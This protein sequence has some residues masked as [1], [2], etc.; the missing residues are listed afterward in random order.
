M[1]FNCQV[2]A[3]LSAIRQCIP[4]VAKTTS[5]PVLSCV[6]IEATGG[7]YDAGDGDVTVSATNH[8]VWVYASVPGA[9]VARNGAV[10][11]PPDKLAA[12]L[13]ESSSDTV[14]IAAGGTGHDTTATVTIGRSRYDLTSCDPAEFPEIRR[15]DA[16]S[17]HMSIPASEIVEG[18]RL[19]AIAADRAEGSKYALKGVLL[20]A[21]DEMLNL[22]A[23]DTRRLA[24]VS[25]AA[26]GAKSGIGKA[27]VP[28]S[29]VSI[30]SKIKPSDDADILVSIHPS[31]V[32]FCLPGVVEIT[33]RVV[34]GAFPPYQKIMPKKRP[35]VQLV[36]TFSEFVA[37][38][39]QASITATAE[40]RRVKY[41]L[42]PGSLQLSAT[43][44]GVGSSLVSQ[45]KPGYDGETVEILL[46]PNYVI[47]G[48]SVLDKAENGTWELEDGD[49][50]CLF[51]AG[52]WMYLVM[53]LANA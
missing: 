17:P 6:K 15:F 37:L 4:A 32:S 2:R 10:V 51:R 19:V 25:V 23:T 47:E 18:L 20:D 16:G 35:P 9:S 44:A 30:L 26:S 50:P 36:T 38:T 3:L 49:K 39:R 13:S 24:V 53:P 45:E 52:N 46:D 43:G 7:N 1:K 29:T 8:D 14:D 21:A 31:E 28:I 11:V 42:S 33:S 48:L 27:V 22:V 40:S 34:E 41:K 5:Q 12:M